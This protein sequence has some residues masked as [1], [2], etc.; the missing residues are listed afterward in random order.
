MQVWDPYQDVVGIELR[1]HEDCHISTLIET[2][3]KD[4]SKVLIVFSTV[5]EECARLVDVAEQRFFGPLSCYGERFDNSP[6]T[7]SMGM[8]ISKT[9][10]LFPAARRS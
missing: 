8:V 2:D 6:V 3:S 1:A 5:A 4:I 7:L 9:D 10:F